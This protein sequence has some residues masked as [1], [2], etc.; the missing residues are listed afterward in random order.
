MSETVASIDADAGSC[1]SSSAVTLRAEPYDSGPKTTTA[2]DA[3]GGGCW[4][5]GSAGIGGLLKGPVA[6][7]VKDELKRAST[8]LPPLFYDGKSDLCTLGSRPGME[9]V[10]LRSP[11]DPYH[12]HHV[13]DQT[14]SLQVRN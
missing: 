9:C 5:R 7:L 14:K 2:A 8:S 6:E 11:A 10:P 4:G 12:Y 3:G 1:S 13:T